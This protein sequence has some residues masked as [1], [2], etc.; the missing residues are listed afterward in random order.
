MVDNP[1]DGSEDSSLF[2]YSFMCLNI[3]VPLI[4]RLIELS[5]TRLIYDEVGKIP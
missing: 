5:E 3:I 1:L 4:R 2:R